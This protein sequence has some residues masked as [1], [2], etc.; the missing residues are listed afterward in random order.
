MEKTSMT[1][2]ARDGAVQERAAAVLGR[3]AI[4]GTH[5]GESLAEVGRRIP[6]QLGDAETG[7]DEVHHDS[8]A[9]KW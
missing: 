7:A 9:R 6:V 8:R 1:F 5:L 4:L 3:P 2:L